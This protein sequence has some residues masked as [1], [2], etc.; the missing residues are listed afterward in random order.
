MDVDKEERELRTLGYRPVPLFELEVPSLN[1]VRTARSYPPWNRRCPKCRER[2][3]WT[4]RV[5]G[6][7]GEPYRLYKCE[8]VPSHPWYVR[9][10]RMQE[11]CAEWRPSKGRDGSPGASM[12]PPP[13]P[14]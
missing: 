13:S 2:L 7:P 8:N 11:E 9:D 3:R 4:T 5:Y 10:V 14:E 12:S 6:K 1:F